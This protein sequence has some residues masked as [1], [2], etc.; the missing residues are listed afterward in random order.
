M[1]IKPTAIA[2]SIMT[3]TLVAGA[4][5][6]KMISS[7][8][9]AQWTEEGSVAVTEFNTDV[10]NDVM[11]TRYPAQTMQGFGGCFNELGGIALKKLG[12]A[13][14]QRVL[15]ALFDSEE[16][17]NF[18]VCRTPV[19]ANDFATEW[20]SY[21]ETPGD[22][23][24]K[25]FSIAH[26]K[27]HLIPY[28]KWALE[29]NPSLRI[30]ASPWSA[31]QWLKTNGHYANRADAINGLDPSKE[32]PTGNDQM[33]L[34]P[35]YLTTYSKYLSRYVS[36][37]AREGI[38]I[39]MLQFQNE[40]YTFNIWPNCSWTPTAMTDF[41][42]NYLGPEFETAHPSV[43]LW[44]GTMNTDRFD[45]LESMLSDEAMARYI[46]GV[47]VQW[48]GKDIVN[49][50]YRKYPQLPIIQ[51]ENECGSG[52]N[53][54]AAAEHTYDLMKKYIADGASLYMYFNMVLSDEC[55]SSWGWKQNAMV[56]VD[57]KSKKATF[58]PE[59]YVMKHFS[60]YVQPGARRLVTMGT[61]ENLT[62]FQNTDGSRVV[63]IYNPEK[64]ARDMTVSLASDEV[65][66]VSM[67]PQSFNTIL[68]TD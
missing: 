15:K 46:K 49:D 18:T 57:S 29:I 16:G 47:G 3:A 12:K 25:K 63:V 39:Y 33:I 27:K 37:Y 19:G 24:L 62:A 34:D 67:L 35:Q 65:I 45:H 55:K 23:E 52:T 40:P 36:E 2:L 17:L 44:L 58:T 66:S 8:P 11:V 31:P 4:T 32:V 60:R 13:E 10:M 6:V 9:D 54:W 21:D 38:N 5:E 1:N 41:I 26:D 50:I 56:V 53:D 7:T 42:G 61:D 59:Y 43:E 20:Y 14:R 64:E 22:F 28:I 68:I 51:T 30:W 48:E